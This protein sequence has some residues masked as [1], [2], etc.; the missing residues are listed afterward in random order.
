M[1]NIA[2]FGI[3]IIIM[4]FA[5]LADNNTVEQRETVDGIGVSG[6]FSTVKPAELSDET[7]RIIGALGMTSVQVFDL[8]YDEKQ[9]VMANLWV[10]VYENGVKQ[11]DVIH[12]GT[13]SSMA[14]EEQTY[15]SQAIIAYHVKQD[16]E[17]RERTL[18]IVASIADESGSASTSNEIV[19][20]EHTGGRMVTPLSAERELRINRPV[21]VLTMIEDTGNSF[22]YDDHEIVRYDE[23][24]E[25]PDDFKNYDRVILF[26]MMVAKE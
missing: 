3:I 15:S 11:E 14:G 7:K 12:F 21:T 5:A 23:T 17:S 20:P 13:G 22:I 6:Q 2:V 16:A 9:P 26:R 10:E 8:T 24:G 19:L 4:G 18:S 1:K 25:V